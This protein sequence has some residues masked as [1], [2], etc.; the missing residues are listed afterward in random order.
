MF[1]PLIQSFVFLQQ[2][3]PKVSSSSESSADLTFEARQP[4]SVNISFVSTQTWQW[5]GV[6]W[7]LINEY[8]VLKK[9]ILML[10]PNALQW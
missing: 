3:L 4:E 2:F 10:K 8:H 1:C 6:S 7:I 9:E 5:L